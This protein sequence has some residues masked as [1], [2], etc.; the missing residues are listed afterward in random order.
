[1][2]FFVSASSS[3][4]F[5]FFFQYER[6]LMLRN[7]P[8]KSNLDHSQHHMTLHKSTSIRK[9]GNKSSRPPPHGKIRFAQLAK[10]IG[11]KWK[12]IGMF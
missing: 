12:T 4:S 2:L 11:P 7:M 1:M 8:S 3:H 6:D 5:S 10:I 9:S